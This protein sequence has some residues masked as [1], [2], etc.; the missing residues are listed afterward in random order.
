MERDKHLPI[1][2]GLMSMKSQSSTKGHWLQQ[3]NEFG[4]FKNSNDAQPSANKLLT[5][6]YKKISPD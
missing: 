1:G 2:E 3:Y 4:I 5:M 6:W